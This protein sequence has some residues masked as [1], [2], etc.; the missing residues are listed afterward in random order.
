MKGVRFFIKYS[1]HCRLSKSKK[2]YNIIFWCWI[3]VSASYLWKYFIEVSKF[4]K[5]FFDYF[6][7]MKV[8]S[9]KNTYIFV[10]TNSQ[11][12]HKTICLLSMNAGTSISNW[13]CIFFHKSSPTWLLVDSDCENFHWTDLSQNA[14]ILSLRKTMSYC[15]CHFPPLLCHISADGKNGTGARSR[16]CQ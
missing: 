6:W 4:G 12:Q 9:F 13:Y 1:F 8:I 16:K 15:T 5:I 14:T 2:L 7:R 10:K 11:I 3:L